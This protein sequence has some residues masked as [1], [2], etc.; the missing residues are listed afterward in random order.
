MF[1]AKLWISHWVLSR[2]LEAVAVLKDGVCSPVQGSVG[3]H[4]SSSR[5]VAGVSVQCPP[6]IFIT[7]AFSRCLLPPTL[8]SVWLHF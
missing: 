8:S 4:L 5:D 3:G 7:V 6:P 1:G 2:P